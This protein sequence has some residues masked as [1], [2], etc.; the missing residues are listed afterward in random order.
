MKGLIIRITILLTGC[1]LFTSVSVLLKKHRSKRFLLQ[2]NGA[3]YIC[4]SV[5]WGIAELIIQKVKRTK[6]SLN[7]E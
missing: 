5:I 7:D 6:I 4:L 2:L 1:L 3:A